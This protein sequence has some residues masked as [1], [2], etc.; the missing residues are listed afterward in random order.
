MRLQ[1]PVRYPGTTK[2][3]PRNDSFVN[4][5]NLGPTLLALAGM[6]T[7]DFMHGSCLMPF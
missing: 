4:Y 6:H 5:T 1:R 3:G 2:A 7:P